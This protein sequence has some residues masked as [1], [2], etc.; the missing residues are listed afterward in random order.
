[1]EIINGS[2]S[3]YDGF[4]ATPAYRSD[5]LGGLGVID[6]FKESLGKEIQSVALMD[7]EQLRFTF[8]DG[9]SVGIQDEGQSCCESRYMVSNDDDL[10][11]FKGSKLLGAE[12][13]AAADY[14]SIDEDEVHEVQFLNIITSAGTFQLASHNEHSGYYG[15]FDVLATLL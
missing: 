2:V 12:L 5:R 4:L 14:A 10:S 7:G 3:Y 6:P 15:G 9:S 1:M 13:V 11:G 8:T